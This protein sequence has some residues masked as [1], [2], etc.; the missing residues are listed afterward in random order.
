VKP[1]PGA[2]EALLAG[3]HGD[4]FSLLGVHAG[5]GGTFARV[6]IPGA[7]RAEAFDLNGRRLGALARVDG[8]GLFEGK[9]LGPPRPV[10]YKAQSAGTQWWVTDPYSFGP[11]LGPVDDFLIAE[12]THLRL[13]DKLG[14]HQISH[15]G[16]TGVHFAVWAPNA[17]RVSVVG[18]FNDWDGRRHVMRSRRDIGVWEIFIPDIGAGRHYKFEIIGLDGRLRPL[19]SDPFA[20]AAELRPSTA[21]LT[22]A[23]PAHVWGDAAHRASWTGIDPRRVPISIYEVHAGSWDRDGEGRFLSWDALA[24]RLIPYVVE[25]GFTHI[26]FLPI[27]EHPYDPSWGYQTTGLFAP[28]ARFGDPSGFARFVDGAH[29]AG[30]GVLIDWVPA[31]FPTDPHGLIRFDGTALYEHEDPR[32]GH[33]P[34]WDTAIYNFGR[35]EVASFL[36]NNALFWAERFHVDGLRVDAVASMLYRD[37]SRKAGEWVPNQE[38]GR[39]NWEA[40]E[41]LRAMNRAVYA[42]APGILTVAEESTSWPGVSRP[43]HDGGLGFGFKWN[44]GFMHDTLLYMAREPVHRAHHHDDITFGLLY[45]FSENFVLPL[46]HDEVVHGKGSLLTKMAGDDWQKFANLRAYYALMWGYPGKKLLFMGQ[47]FAQRREWSEAQA[48]D[49]HLLGAPAHEGVKRLVKDLNRLY[50]EKPALHARDCESEGFAWAIA[51]DRANSVFAW[52]RR[53]PGAP[54]VAVIA[55]MTPVIRKD[56]RVP[57]PAEG[58]WKEMVNSDALHYGGS[59][60]GNLGAVTCSGGSA[61]LTL[62]PLATIML[63]HRE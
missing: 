52:V 16:A 62:P 7:E 21:S 13:Y 44:M 9:L 57:L 59:G 50:R 45:A 12:G 35:R 33:H 19:K 24:D 58:T 37:Y 17:R 51:D 8:R 42:T 6:W 48:L 32:Q 25:M 31:H 34:D 15:E 53:A 26:E 54:P 3:R 1:A 28:S 36:L 61:S 49:W 39:E 56:Y 46:S 18:D 5:P 47:E 43:V 63:E 41:F 23:P 29:R 14:A 30:L 20:F 40:V 2:L 55:N 10:K 22:T 11:V 38:G 27:S 60:V 4:P